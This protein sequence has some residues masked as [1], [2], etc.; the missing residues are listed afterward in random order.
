MD[1]CKH[2]MMRLR[3]GR[4]TCVECGA[5]CTPPENTEV[6]VIQSGYRDNIIESLKQIAN[7]VPDDVLHEI[8]IYAEYLNQR[9]KG[10]EAFASV[11]KMVGNSSGQ[12]RGKKAPKP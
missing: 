4:L 7:E 2:Y 8:E 3:R 11:I 5:D 9:R 1:D 10:S 12:Y 6:H